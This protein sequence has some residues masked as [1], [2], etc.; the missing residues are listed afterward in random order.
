[1]SKQFWVIGAEYSDLQ[2]VHP[3]DGTTRLFGPYENYQDARELW[4]A[5]V[6]MSRHEATTRYTIVSNA[7]AAAA[8]NASA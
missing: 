8:Q 2:F 4:R 1:M 7:A 3:V 5:R 6:M